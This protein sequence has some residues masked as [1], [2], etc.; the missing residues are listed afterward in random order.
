[1]SYSTAATET[2]TA[3]AVPE[4]KS[5]QRSYDDAIDFDDRLAATVAA[6]YGEADGGRITAATTTDT[7]GFSR[8]MAAM[9]NSETLYPIMMITQSTL[10]L[11]IVLFQKSVSV[12]VKC[13]LIVVYL[14]ALVITVLTFK[15]RI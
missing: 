12:L 2:I 9:N 15:Y 8:M 1:M 11:V 3:F 6:N 7:K 13:L 4:F 14:I 5:P 10:S